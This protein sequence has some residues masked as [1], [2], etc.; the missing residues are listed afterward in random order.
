V[1]GR[2]TLAAPDPA[3]IRARFP[4]GETVEVRPRFN[5]APGDDILAVTTDREG[6][7]RGELLQWGLVPHWAPEPVSPVKMINARAE[8]LQDKPAF[9]DALGR[10]RCLVLADGFY[11]WAPASGVGARPY[12]QAFHITRADGQPFAFAGLWSIWRR[13]EVELRSCTIITTQANPALAPL[14]DRMPVILDPDAESTWLDPA[15]PRAG[16]AELLRPLP[17]AATSIRPVG[18]AV[19]DARYDGAECLAEVGATPEP[20]PE[21]LPRGDA[22][23]T[24]F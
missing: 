9:R 16:L 4:I 18:P 23:A 21:G 6:T 8:T 12:K 11:E 5:V 20:S 7:P 15:T 19:N 22:Q 2:Y 14:H 24:L 3:Q 1:C 17:A 10:F 13:E